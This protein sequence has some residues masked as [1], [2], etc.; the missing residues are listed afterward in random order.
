MAM[1]QFDRIIESSHED[2]DDGTTCNSCNI[3]WIELTEKY[4]DWVQYDICDEYICPKC[5]DKRDIT[6][7]DDFSVV[8][9]S[10]HKY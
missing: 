10:D 2:E 1:Q 9:A 7:D 3:P 8:S 6:A 5:C 4:G